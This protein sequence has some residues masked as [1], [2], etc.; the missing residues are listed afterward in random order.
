[1][2]V[3]LAVAIAIAAVWSVDRMRTIGSA[4]LTGLSLAALVLTRF[5]FLP[6]ALGLAGLVAWRARAAHAL[7]V[8]AVGIA[9]IAPWL[10]FSRAASGT[11]LPPRIGENLFVST[12][13]WAEPLV[14]RVNVDVLMEL[15]E[16]LVERELG[17]SPSPRARDRLLR[18]RAIAYA[19]AHPAKA[20]A[21]KLKNL[22]WA[23]QPRLLPF[24]ER[25]GSAEI[26]DGTLVIP[27]QAPR[28]AAFEL[29]AGGF[30][31]ALL[32]GAA[33]GLWKRRYHLAG[34]DASLLLVAGSVLAVN[35]VFFPTSRLLAPMTVVLMFYTAVSLER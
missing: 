25:R 32:V 22:V 7:T 9:A 3:T 14:P 21:L 26:V 34:A 15:T 8:A 29:A 33:A 1:M 16:A 20:I 30:Q 2:E 18:D 28:P 6:I 10:V 5:S 24:T 31:A 27:P 4:A 23:L 11:L 35:V 17:P 13:E 19:A 12:N